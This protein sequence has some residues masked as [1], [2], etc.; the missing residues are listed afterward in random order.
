MALTSP[1]KSSFL[2]RPFATITALALITAC[3]ESTF[4]SSKTTGAKLDLEQKKQIAQPTQPPGKTDNLVP[5]PEPAPEP[6]PE[7]L[8]TTAPNQP[9]DTAFSIAGETRPKS[10]IL[11]VI[12]DSS[13]MTQ[14]LANVTAGFDSLTPSLFPP[15]SRVG[16]M[17][18]LPG[19]PENLSEVHP[20]VNNYVGLSKSPGFL[21]LVNKSNIE[22]FLEQD[23]PPSGNTSVLRNVNKGQMEARFS[24][25]ACTKGFFAPGEKPLGK[26]HS[27]FKAAVQTPLL[28]VGCEAG[29]AS[30]Q[31]FLA[32]RKQKNTPVFRPGADVSVVF[33]SDT[34]DPGCDRPTVAALAPTPQALKVLVDADPTT[35]PASVRFHAIAPNEQ[36]TPST[37]P[38]LS[39]GKRYYEAADATG[40][41]KID[42]CNET[43]YSAVLQ[44]IAQGEKEYSF[45]IEGVQRVLAVKLNGQLLQPS[46][47]RLEQN[48]V[49]VRLEP[50]ANARTLSITWE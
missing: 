12:D 10:D 22:S 21:R 24:L 1:G 43:N 32:L 46:S 7:P 19:N 49:K 48:Q 5:K 29:L 47:Y 28:G 8:V 2:L 44:R 11:F 41:I 25:E 26:D 50:H 23:F 36:C 13:S 16:V 33:L 17:Y 15:D 30:L 9:R 45:T 42:V 3:G 40:G 27:C 35:P 18:T 6:E 20:Q 4:N 39:Y 31:Q 14:V 34:H 37:E 38:I